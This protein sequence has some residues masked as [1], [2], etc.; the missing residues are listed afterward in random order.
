MGAGDG[1][2]W[3]F[4][5]RTGKPLWN[6]PFSRRGI[7]ATPLVVGNQVFAAH[8][9]ENVSG[10]AMGAIVALNIS[11]TGDETKAE[12]VWKREEV[13]AGYSEPV[14]VDGRVYLVDDRCKMWIFDAET[15]ET[16]VERKAFVGSRQRS[17]LLY[18]DGKI[19]VL[20]E[21]GRWAVVK[22]T[23]DGFEVLSK[24]RVDNADFAGSP[25]VADGRLY[26]PSSKTLY[27][28]A[29]E[30]GTQASVDM[31]SSMGDETPLA[32]NPDVAQI[33]VVPAESVVEPGKQ[34]ELSTRLFNRLGLGR[35]LRHGSTKRPEVIDHGLID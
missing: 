31:A 26:F 21:N 24:G 15:G 35:K 19:Y 33:L 30:N 5:P 28:V 22:P 1:A 16:I 9:E 20:T 13:V 10:S 7:Y 8:S 32:E 3:G 4:Q 17:S 25:I 2:I 18:A 11:G 12:E 14:F 34:I 27:C 29:T 6:F 23:E